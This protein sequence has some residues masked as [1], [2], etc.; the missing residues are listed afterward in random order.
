MTSGT[1]RSSGRAREGVVGEITPA[2][3]T[4]GRE[5]V[6]RV[7]NLVPEAKL[8]FMMRNPIE[9][10]WSQA[11]MQFDKSGK[12]PKGSVR[13][14][15]LQRNFESEGSRV[16]TDYL[17]TLEA[18]ESY[19]PEDQI[20]AGF[21]EDISFFPAE[22]LGRVYEFLGVN[23]SFKPAGVGQ[24]VHTRSAGRA[25]HASYGLSGAALSG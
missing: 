21:L 19:Y 9:R 24:K 14:R 3:S 22:L 1:P 4:L 18:W 15:K 11:V 23:H 12:Q 20:F 5:S 7:Y 6:A 8:I 25:P 17:R 2:Y 16:R 13:E 10:A